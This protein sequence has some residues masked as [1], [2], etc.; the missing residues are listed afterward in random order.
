M[1]VKTFE[2]E[3]KKLST[4]FTNLIENYDFEEYDFHS[5]RQTLQDYIEQ[6]YPNF[7]DY[8]RS[9]YVMM[10]IELFAFYGEMMAYRVDMSYNELFLS[11][12]KDRRNIIKLADMLGYKFARL[13]PSVSIVKKD[14]SDSKGA[15][16]LL[17]KK[18][19]QGSLND[20]LG[21]AA[22]I[23][24]EP[25]P[26]P[27]DTYY[28]YKMDYLLKT[29]D[30][31]DF[32]NTLNN[33]FKRLEDFSEQSGIKTKTV[34]VDNF[35][36]F[37]RSI[38][39]DKFQMR[40]NP[41]INLYVD[42]AASR[43]M[44][45]L[46]SLYFDEM[47][48][49][50]TE[51]T[52]DALS[53]S[54]ENLYAQTVELGFEFVIRHDKGNNIL[55][56]NVYLYIPII[57]G[58]TFSREV[59][60]PKTIRSY[61]EV[62]YEPNIFNNPT[63][64]RQYDEQGTLVRT[65][66]EVE[67]LNN[68]PHR[69][70]YEINNTP[71]GHI[72]L[73]FGNGKNVE[74]LLPA[75]KTTLF[76]RKNVNNTDEV[77]NVRN[78]DYAEIF[79]AIQYYDSL[80]GKMQDVTIGLP[81]LDKFNSRG[82]LPAESNEEIK[83]MAKKI[84]S[85]GDRFVTAKDYE[86]AGML[87][88]RVKYT[89]VVLRSYIGKNSARISNEFLDVYLDQ[90]KNNITSYKVVDS[91]SNNAS[92]IY[93][94]VPNAFFTASSVA[95]F[96]DSLKFVANGEEFYFDIFDLDEISPNNWFKYPTE[97]VDSANK[98][99]IIK[100]TNRFM[101]EI[102]KT[103]L[104]NVAKLNAILPL[105]YGI[106]TVTFSGS[107]NKIVSF[108]ITLNKV[109]DHVKVSDKFFERKQ[110]IMSEINNLISGFNITNISLVK[111]LN[112]YLLS[113]NYK[114]ENVTLP[115]DDL[116]FIWTHYR[117]DDIYLNP[118]KANIIELYVTGVKKDFKKN[119]YVFEPLSSSEINKL[120]ADI[121][122]RKMVSDNVMVYNSGYY[123][124]TVALKIFK[125]RRTAITGELMRSKVETV[126]DR[127]FDVA[128]IPL[129]KHFYLSRLIEWLHT[130]ITEIQ[131]IEVMEDI[132]GN[133]ITPSSTIEILGEK[134]SFTQIVEKKLN[135]NGVFSPMRKIEIIV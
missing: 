46:Q 43:K 10:L 3:V 74:V 78:A 29:V 48:Y 111:S 59:K 52:E 91:S 55:D 117:S 116:S 16:M 87:H 7:N 71:E 35:E 115:E 53:Y 56:K 114:S 129:G 93:I 49:F 135:V 99:T 9:D 24:F 54:K 57:Q 85:V 121:N 113:L 25:M 33:I 86:T 64:I 75:S 45:E 41:N 51:N 4:E 6:T 20:I 34:L 17:Y 133:P 76:Y 39:V 67:D 102:Q 30:S 127:F 42:Y 95:G 40:F 73:I 38:F 12:A 134:I 72:E 90:I 84:R 109:V 105:D 124:I 119:I 31:T 13:E 131:H 2:R 101:V 65:Y 66:H 77:Y 14:I 50:N 98:G 36:F 132:H 106:S 122:K 110:A 28:P 80:V 19:Q 88:P 27:N 23:V 1:S 79:L 32:M 68:T 70:A 112:G 83:H 118:S 26:L 94:H 63:V 5:I 120:V 100:L 96:Y 81:L 47:R 8:F 58:G 69:Y 15:G 126:L 125:D 92:D 108:V 104:S 22:K 89:T 60:A 62:V 37:E 103:A 123:E 11:T 130:N 97:M 107:T 18:R 61:T 21:K 44:F 128:N 82:G